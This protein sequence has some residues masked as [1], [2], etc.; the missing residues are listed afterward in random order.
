MIKAAFPLFRGVALSV[1]AATAAFALPSTSW[2]QAEVFAVCSGRLSA[3]AAQ[4]NA[5]GVPNHMETLAHMSNFDMLLEA[6]LPAAMQD[7]VPEQQVKIWRAQG[8]TEIARLLSD[9]RYGY[10]MMMIDAANAGLRER[11][12]YCRSLILAGS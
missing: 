9:A 7:G 11:I 3:L 6:V 12:T 2:Q 10:D 4:Q 8:W 5:D 1:F